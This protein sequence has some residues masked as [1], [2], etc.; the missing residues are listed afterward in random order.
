ME[1]FLSLPSNK[2]RIFHTE[3]HQL[4]KMICELY[5][6]CCYNFSYFH[7]HAFWLKVRLKIKLWEFSRLFYKSYAKYMVI[8]LESILFIV[9]SRRM[10]TKSLFWHNVQQTHGW[11]F[12]GKSR[13]FHSTAMFLS[14]KSR[15]YVTSYATFSV[16]F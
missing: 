3:V 11:N 4:T 2:S 1:H 10:K 14:M 16:Q 7:A 5:V 8:F 13:R 15:F 12:E 9:R 6:Y